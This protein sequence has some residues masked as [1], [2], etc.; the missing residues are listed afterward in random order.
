MCF[1]EKKAYTP[2][3]PAQPESKMDKEI[4]TGEYFLKEKERK[5]KKLQERQEKQVDYKTLVT[6]FKLRGHS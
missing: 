2:F 5:M 1:R 6:N 3:P 4:A